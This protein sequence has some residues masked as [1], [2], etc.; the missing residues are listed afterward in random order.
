MANL[1]LSSP[2]EG[3]ETTL[4]GPEQS[5]RDW[6]VA[7]LVCAFS[8]LFLW[9]FLDFTGFL[10]D[11]GITLQGAQ[12]ILDGQVPYRD[13]FAFYTPGSY[14]WTALRF[15]LLGTSFFAARV[16]LL[17][18]GGLFSVCLYMLAR[19]ICPRWLA[20]LTAYLFLM[21]G[22]PRNFLVLHNWDS[23]VLAVLAL[24]AAVRWAESS[25][26]GW[27][28]ATGSL[29]SLTF[30][31]EQSKGAG[32][33]V[34]LG[35]G[36]L[37]LA[38]LGRSPDLLRPRNLSALAGGLAWPAILTFG[39]FASQHSLRPMLAD[40]FWP[41][42]HY[43]LANR[44]PYASVPNSCEGSITLYRSGSVLRSLF[45]MTLTSPFFV[46]PF[47]PFL[48]LALLV[49]A[50][51]RGKRATQS[52]ATASCCVLASACGVGLVLSAVAT[53]RPD[54]DHLIYVSPPLILLLGMVLSGRLV[55]S[56]LLTEV[57]PLLLTFLIVTFTAFGMMCLLSGPRRVG[58][59]LETRRGHVK[60][61][62]CDTVLPYLQRH[63]PAG[64]E[65]FVY[66]HQPLY[67]F[68]TAT[69]SPIR[70]D[71]LQ[72]GMHSEEEF[73]EARGQLAAHLPRAVVWAPAFNTELIPCFWPATTQQVLSKDLIRGFILAQY[74]VCTTLRAGQLP[75]VF[76]VRKDLPCPEETLPGRP[77]HLAR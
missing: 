27:A 38:R 69:N 34:G 56:R 33:I 20:G 28:F 9:P 53:G 30:L 62:C 54:V 41:L 60:L 7:L 25:R 40:W 31:F 46:V 55:Q 63:I 4:L 26:R 29:V 16:V 74:R 64:E 42:H 61:P 70:F 57:Q 12:R 77:R 47:L 19:R 65:I 14:Y 2:A 17:F 51:C 37:V 59:S 24:Y 49:P 8:V 67:Y 72:L 43:S 11:E 58:Q 66:P 52:S 13:F 76:L 22:L 18:Y 32:L 68:F 50:A 73:E 15:K 36:F 71:Y 10:G 35:L 3:Q 45:I 23:T 44:L 39:Y 1:T 6:A 21:I 5:A 48:G 75:Y